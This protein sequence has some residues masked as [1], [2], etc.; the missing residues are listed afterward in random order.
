MLLLISYFRPRICNSR[1]CNRQLNNLG[2]FLITSMGAQATREGMM[3]RNTLEA[4]ENR[5]KKYVIYTP[6][7]ILWG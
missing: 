7:Q 1:T 5:L 6:R 2:T 4:R 3:T